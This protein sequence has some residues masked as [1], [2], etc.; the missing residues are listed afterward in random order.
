MQTALTGYSPSNATLWTARAIAA[1]VILFW[2][3]DAVGHMLKPAPVV[4]AFARQGVALGLSAPIGVLQLLLL[5]AYLFPRT[6]LLGAVLMTGYLGG[7]TAINLRAGDPA[8]EVLFPII[9]GILIW[10]PPYLLD[11][12]CRA[13]FRFE[14]A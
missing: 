4:D 7:A 8:F 2:L 9:F 11:E 5:A 13:I 1:L 3:F 10:G 14:R 12:R 6:R